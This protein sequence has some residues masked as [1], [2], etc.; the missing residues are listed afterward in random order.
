MFLTLVAIYFIDINW[1]I[2]KGKENKTPKCFR[3][4]LS[5][6]NNQV[7][8][9]NLRKYPKRVRVTQD[10]ADLVGLYLQT[11]DL[12]LL[13]LQILEI[14]CLSYAYSDSYRTFS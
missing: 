12:L 1:Q 4:K 10:T 3:K 6:A 14:L 8:R 13:P 5:L 9:F 7:N 11:R 2:Q